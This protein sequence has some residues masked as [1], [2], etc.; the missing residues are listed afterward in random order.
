M[1]LRRFVP[2]AAALGAV[3]CTPS[4]QQDP[5][6]AAIDVAVFDPTNSKIPLPNDLVFQALA[7][8]QIPA[9]AQRDLLQIFHAAALTPGTT[10]CAN[11]QPACGAF[12]SDQEV[13]ITIDFQR[14]N[15]DSK[16]GALTLVPAP[17]DLTKVVPCDGTN[18][19]TCNVAV[20]EIAGPAPTLA[21]IDAPVAADYVAAVD[22]GTLT[23]HHKLPTTPN[24]EGVFSRRWT[25]TPRWRRASA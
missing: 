5:N 19:A 24:S 13:A 1:L 20:I 6:P 14:E 22:H 15:I 2:L 8:G 17:L 10:A 18:G 12:P 16:T 21:K 11:G 25:A 3:A 4:I 7:L 23:L 9:G